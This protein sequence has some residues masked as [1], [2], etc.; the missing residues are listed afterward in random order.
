MLEIGAQPFASA[1][2]SHKTFALNSIKGNTK[3]TS[4]VLLSQVAKRVRKADADGATKTMSSAYA[5]APTK[6]KPI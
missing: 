4:I 6:R 3:L 1:R 2:Q 5:T